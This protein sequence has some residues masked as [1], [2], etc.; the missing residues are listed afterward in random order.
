L[1]ATLAL[2][3]DRVAGPPVGCADVRMLDVG[4]GLAVVVRTR[5]RT[6]LY[7]TGAAFRGGS[8]MASL[9]VLP[10]LSANGIKRIDRLVVSHSDIDHSGGT[11]RIM[12]NMHVGR[13]LAGEPAS[14]VAAGAAPCTAGETWRWDGV[15]FRVLYPSLQSLHAGND[16]SCVILVEAGDTRLLLT[17]D[18]GAG[19]ERLLVSSG[20]VGHVDAIVVPHHGSNTSSSAP[21]VRSVSAQLALVSAGYR[22]RWDLPK[23]EVVQRWREAGA[24]VLTTAHEGAIGARLCDRAGIVSVSRNRERAHRVWHEPA[25]P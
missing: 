16:S 21:F 14:L 6:L 7:D 13:L 25:T 8:D 11:A 20:A 23:P 10:Y 15:A 9:V 4:Q 24:E 12:G 2:A 17:G 1:L 5:Q 18:I 3:S 19:V 22:N